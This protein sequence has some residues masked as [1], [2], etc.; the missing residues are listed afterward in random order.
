MVLGG[1]TGLTQVL[2]TL[3]GLDEMFVE[4]LK[5]IEANVQPDPHVTLWVIMA[6]EDP[7]MDAVAGELSQ[8]RFAIPADETFAQEYG[9]T[10]SGGPWEGAFAAALFLVSKEGTLFYSEIPQDFDKGFD[11]THFAFQAGKAYHSYNGEGC[12]SI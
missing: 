7:R 1:H 12:E 5:T 2:V 8:F 11:L 3:P 9:V 6:S 10:L 4:A